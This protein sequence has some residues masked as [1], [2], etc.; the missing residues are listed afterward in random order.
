ME[1]SPLKVLSNAEPIVAKKPPVEASTLTHRDLVRGPFWQKIPA[2]REVTEAQFLDHNWQAKNSIVKIDKLIS[3]VQGL[4]SPE[5]LKDI[6][7]GM[8]KAPMS[9]RVSP[10]LVSLSST[11]RTLTSIPSA[12][13]S[14]RSRRACSPITR[15]SSSTPFTSRTTPP[16]PASRTGTSTRRSFCR[17]TSARCTRQFLYAEPR[18]RSRHRCRV[19][20]VHLRASVETSAGSGRFRYIESRPELEDIVISGGGD[21]Y[22]LRA[23]QLTEI[24]EALLAMLNI[25]RMRF[26]TKGPA[27]MRCRKILT[28]EP[29]VGRCPGRR[30]S[31]RGRKLRTRRWS[32]TRTSTTPNEITQKGG[33]TE[34]AMNALMERGIVVRNQS[35]LQRGVNDSPSRR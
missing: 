22:Q 13:S 21:A 25:C 30:S 2:Y 12:R 11:G 5:F 10:Y 28:D 18:H 7:L 8:K 23:T 20:K 3:T 16:S 27:V 35:V 24:G 6:E 4:S 17:S 9:V 19:E 31:R 1:T 26:A 32:F 33:I 34:D 14:S 29:A 15:S